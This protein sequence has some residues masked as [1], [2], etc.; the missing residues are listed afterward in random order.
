ME[1]NTKKIGQDVLKFTVLGGSAVIA[2][3]S[4][5][6]LTKSNDL[7]SAIMPAITLLVGVSAFSYAMTAEKISLVPTLDKNQGSDEETSNAIGSLRGKGKPVDCYSEC[8]KHGFSQE[9]CVARCSG[10]SPSTSMFIGMGRNARGL[11]PN[12][13]TNP[14]NP[15]VPLGRL[16]KG[17]Q[18]IFGK[19]TRDAECCTWTGNSWN[20]V[21][22]PCTISA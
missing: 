10:G 18:M 9:Q 1:V 5:M 17:D 19:G 6:Q 2:V 8:R 3:N 16:R 12:T 11:N 7:K 14:T 13:I 15:N 22:A 21:K 4:I 20:C